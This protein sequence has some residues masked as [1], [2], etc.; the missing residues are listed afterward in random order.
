ME[1]LLFFTF[2]DLIAFIIPVL[3]GLII[4]TKR[5]KRNQITANCLLTW[6]FIAAVS[7]CEIFST[8]YTTYSYRHNKLYNN[9]K[10]NT[11]F[12]YDFAYIVFFAIVMVVAV[13]LFVQELRLRK[14]VR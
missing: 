8:I 10:F 7:F 14:I 2:I 1:N 11:V 13:V 4:F 9:D 12:N 5:R 3:I 6:L